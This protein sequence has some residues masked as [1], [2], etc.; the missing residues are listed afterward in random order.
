MAA[1][2]SIQFLPEVFRTETNKKFLNATMDQLISD[3]QLKKITGYIGRKKAPSYKVT[4]SYIIEPTNDRQNYQLEPSI[5]I[6]NPV[7]DKIEFATTYPDIIN[8]IKYY[9]G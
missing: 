1:K 6:K 2:K 8:Q 4:D 5:I 7:D 3:P 9:G